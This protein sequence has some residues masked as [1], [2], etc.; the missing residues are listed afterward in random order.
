MD[1]EGQWLPFT[2]LRYA[3]VCWVGRGDE[4]VLVRTFISLHVAD[5]KGKLADI[6]PTQYNPNA[7]TRSCS[8]KTIKGLSADAGRGLCGWSGRHPLN[9]IAM[10]A[11]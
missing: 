11:M 8:G 2:E 7:G 3:E 4:F 6:A 9:G 10:L 5:L 1:S